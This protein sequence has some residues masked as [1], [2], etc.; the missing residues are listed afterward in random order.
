V[1]R[2]AHRNQ[3]NTLADVRLEQ[4]RT[5]YGAQVADL[6]PPG[7]I[8]QNKHRETHGRDWDKVTRTH[9]PASFGAKVHIWITEQLTEARLL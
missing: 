1:R 5:T 7:N 8:S 4:A 2:D 9:V 3:Y 6:S